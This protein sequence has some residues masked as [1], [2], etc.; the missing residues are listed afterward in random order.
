MFVVTVAFQIK[1]GQ[2]DH[3]M[4][5]MIQNAKTSLTDEVECYQFDVCRDGHE[6]FLY[7][8]YEDRPAFDLH[9]KS[10]HFLTFDAAVSEMVQAKVVRVFDEVHR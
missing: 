2:I 1:D 7:E 8:V 6:V 3:F 9:L 4:P 10:E 5:L